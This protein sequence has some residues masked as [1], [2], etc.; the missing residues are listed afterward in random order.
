[1]INIKGQQTVITICVTIAIIFY[2]AFT[3][4][5]NAVLNVNSETGVI[6]IGILTSTGIF[7]FCFNSLVW[8]YSKY[9]EHIFFPKENI[10]GEW[11]YKLEING[12]PE[13]DRYGICKIEKHNGELL[14]SGTHFH[15][16]AGRLTSMFTTD[17]AIIDKDKLIINYASTGV[18]SDVYSRKGI[19][20]L[21][22]EGKPPVRIF[23]IWTDVLHGSNKGKIFM[24]KR[25]NETDKILEELG[26]P[27][28]VEQLRNILQIN[29]K[30]ISDDRVIAD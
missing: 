15:P 21:S 29:S 17:Y 30:T 7:L 19:Y 5:V 13:G 14:A 20:Y 11:F 3:K 4:Y 18:D 10:V 6:I 12:K 26:Y 27:F 24:Q 9:F 22:T 16:T 2:V 8:I 1:M 25:S 23:G 28:G